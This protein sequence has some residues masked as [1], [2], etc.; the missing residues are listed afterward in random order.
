MNLP[1]FL[2]IIIAIVLVIDT[3]VV[4]VAGFYIISLLRTVKKMADQAQDLA[5][6]TQKIKNQAEVKVLDWLINLFNKRSFS[7]NR[8]GGGK[9]GK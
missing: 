6:F 9:N 3:I 8:K 7:A 2:L 5:E 1:E 4:L